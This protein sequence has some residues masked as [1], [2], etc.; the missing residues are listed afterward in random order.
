MIDQSKASL[1]T[2]NNRIENASGQEDRFGR[3]DQILEFFPVWSFTV[4]N[5]TGTAI[6]DDQRITG[7]STNASGTILKV[8]GSTLI[9]SLIHI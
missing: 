9:L 3:R 5:S 1:K 6:T 8:D 7:L 4:T 2:I